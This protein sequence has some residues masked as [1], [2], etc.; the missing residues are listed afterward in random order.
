[1]EKDGKKG[2]RE[3]SRKEGRKDERKEG[4][5]EYIYGGMNKEWT[6]EQMKKHVKDP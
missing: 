4:R 2:G 6:K 5:N 3:Y 1:M